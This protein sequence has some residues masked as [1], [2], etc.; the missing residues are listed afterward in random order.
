LDPS[1]I[2]QLLGLIHPDQEVFRNTGG[3]HAAALF[4]SSRSIITERAMMEKAAF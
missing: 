2:H 3:L 4:S 1:R